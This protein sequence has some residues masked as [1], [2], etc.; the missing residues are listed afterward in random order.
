MKLAYYHSIVFSYQFVPVDVLGNLHIELE[1]QVNRLTALKQTF[2]LNEVM[3]LSTCNR[4][5]FCIYADQKPDEFF[6]RNFLIQLYPQLS[7]EH[8]NLLASAVK[9]YNGMEVVEHLLRVASSIDSM[10]VGEREII[11]QVRNAYEFARK[12]QLCGDFIRIIIRHTVESAKQVYTET[13][14]A[15]NPVSVVSLAYHQLQKQNIPLDARIIIIGAGMTNINMSRF[16]KK[17]GFENFA[18]FNRTLPKAQSLSNDLNGRAYSLDDLKNY[19]QGFDVIITCTGSDNHIVDMHLYES[20]LQ[21]E[22]SKK[23]I[24][25]IAIPQDISPEV[26]DNYTVNY[27]SVNFLQQIA[28][29]NLQ[30]RSQEIQHVE[31]ILDK[32]V[33]EFNDLFKNRAVEIAM[34]SVPEKVKEIK[35]KALQQVFKNEMENLDGESKDVVEKIIDYMEKKYMSMPMLMAKEIL[36]N[37]K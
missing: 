4:V 21:G 3:F 6:I 27:I 36:L 11:T 37:S 12:H 34:R 14:I 17:H 35:S 23:T 18:I 16:L 29:Q 31:S 28:K 13:N 30:K 7:E 33:E 20:L 2:N 1:N 25:D 5:E 22:T 15:R 8:L 10:V 24:I 9:V 26:L 19:Q 32:K